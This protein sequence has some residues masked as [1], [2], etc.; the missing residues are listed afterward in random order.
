MLYLFYLLIFSPQIFLTIN[1]LYREEEERQNGRN[2]KKNS[3]KIIIENMK[4][5]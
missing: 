2:K 1:T 3:K 5:N 4:N